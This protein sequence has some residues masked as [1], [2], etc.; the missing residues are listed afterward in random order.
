MSE[1]SKHDDSKTPLALIPT[2]PIEQV[3][4]ILNYGQ[5]KYGQKDNWRKGMDWS[6]LISATMR[7]MLA[8]NEGDNTDEESG[9]SHL[10]HAACN[11]LFLL[12]YQHYKLGKDDRYIRATNNEHP[13]GPRPDNLL[14]S[15]GA[16][17]P[18]ERPLSFA[19]GA[20]EMPSLDRTSFIE[21]RRG[22]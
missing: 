15:S 18:V 16:S 1:A 3:A 11:L 7:H 10:A 19:A 13:D 4:S 21:G 22:R 14:T 17:T 5:K 12:E 20:N 2:Y 6:R 8:W 9:L